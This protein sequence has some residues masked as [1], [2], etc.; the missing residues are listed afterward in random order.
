[1]DIV[2]KLDFL[3]FLH[4]EISNLDQLAISCKLNH[5]YL[6][7]KNVHTKSVIIKGNHFEAKCIKDLRY[8]IL[9]LSKLLFMGIEISKGILNCLKNKISLILLKL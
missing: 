1:M 4:R 5:K 6:I 7:I 2:N 3:H 8:Q 9:S